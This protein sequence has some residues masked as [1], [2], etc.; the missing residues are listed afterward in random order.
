MIFHAVY[1][2]IRQMKIFFYERKSLN[3]SHSRGIIVLAKNFLLL[4]TETMKIDRSGNHLLRNPYFGVGMEKLDRDAFDPNGVYD[5]VADLG[6]KWVRLQSGWAK[7]EKSKGKYDFA[8]LDDIVDNLRSRSLTPWICLCYGNPLYDERAK[9]VSGGVGCPP[10]DSDESI[11]AW[12]NYCA[13]LASRYVGKVEYYEVWN[14]PEWLWNDVCDPQKYSEFCE[15]TARAVKEGDPAAKIIAGSVASID[16]SFLTKCVETGID[17]YADALSYHAY[18]YD[19]R[20]FAELNAYYDGICRKNGSDIKIIHGESG[21]QSRNGGNGAFKGFPTDPVKQAKHL[22]RQMV[23]DCM[24]GA[25][26]SSYFTAVDMHENLLAKAGKPIKKHGYFGLLS[27]SFD[28][29]GIACGPFVPKPSY[30]ALQN[31]C[32]FFSDGIKKGNVSCWIDRKKDDRNGR[33]LRII[34]RRFSAI[35]SFW[36][37]ERLSDLTAYCVEKEDAIAFVYWESTD[38]LKKKSFSCG[39]KISF[40]E[41]RKPR[42]VDLL[43]G[44]VT[45]LVYEEKDGL[46]VIRNLPVKDYP[47]AVVFGNFVSVT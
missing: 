13:A 47:L 19:E 17:K 7:T 46:I 4:Y 18:T 44:D 30:Y 20:T 22:L 14:E 10:I 8:W 11:R 5:K 32:A 29:C 1:S 37:D 35:G 16:P 6:V 27:A 21:S 15:R 34:K 40:Y 45:D 39:M 2:F 36:H 41:K 42:L 9:K 38:L 33:F 28:R 26:F 25:F 23:T 3:K 43:T 12:E 31:V 24:S